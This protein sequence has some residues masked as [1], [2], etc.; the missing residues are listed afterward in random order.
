MLFHYFSQILLVLVQCNHISYLF[1]GLDSKL[2]LH[3]MN[4]FLD[5]H[6]YWQFALTPH[7]SNVLSPIVRS[8]S[9]MI[10]TRIGTHE[11]TSIVKGIIHDEF[12]FFIHAKKS[13]F[14]QEYCHFSLWLEVAVHSYS[15]ALQEI[16]LDLFNLLFNQRWDDFSPCYCSPVRFLFIQNL[17]CYAHKLA[18]RL[19]IFTVYWYQSLT[20]TISKFYRTADPIYSRMLFLGF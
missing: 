5:L 20:H 7:I 14:F 2:E 1:S 3:L 18:Y 11:L 15:F 9:D 13:L 10:V 17:R 4:V 8:S 19:V 16:F 12:H 6:V